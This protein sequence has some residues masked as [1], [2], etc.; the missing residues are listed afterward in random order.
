[1]DHAQ[2]AERA[3]ESLPPFVATMPRAVK[4]MHA[5]RYGGAQT[6]APYLEARNDELNAALGQVIRASVLLGEGAFEELRALCAEYANRNADHQLRRGILGAHAVA[7]ALQGLRYDNDAWIPLRSE[8]AAFAAGERSSL[9]TIL[10]SGYVTAECTRNPAA[11][12]GLLRELITQHGLP[13]DIVSI[14]VPIALVYA[15]RLLDDR[16]SLARL[17]TEGALWSDQQP[18]LRA[19]VALARGAAAAICGRNELAAPL[20][21]EAHAQFQSLSAPYFA[22]LADQFRG[23]QTS[24]S[25]ARPANT[26]RREREI[27]ALVADGLT[28]REI[29]ERLVLS[30]RTVEGH[31]ANLFAKVNVNSRTQLATWYV[32]SVSP[33]A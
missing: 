30:E 5:F 19:H 8:V 22:G 24:R 27:A 18:M 16:E 32:R 7:S 3:T 29:A 21:H 33:V 11:A 17:A 14:P 20:L 15:A 13:C 9:L 1:M 6:V 25:E 4:M 28:N 10:M 2:R 12:I 26:T 31:I 23:A